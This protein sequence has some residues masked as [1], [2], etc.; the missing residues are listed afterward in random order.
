M[1]ASVSLNAANKVTN[2]VKNRANAFLNAYPGSALLINNWTQIHAL[3][4]I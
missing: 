1:D 3:V 2:G 4:K